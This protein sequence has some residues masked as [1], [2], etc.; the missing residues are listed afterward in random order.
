MLCN[1]HAY[2]FYLQIEECILDKLA[3][4]ENS[5]LY[6]ALHNVGDVVPSCESVCF[7]PSVQGDTS[8]G[9]HVPVATLSSP[10]LQR[11]IFKIAGDKV[12]GYR[13]FTG[14]KSKAI[15]TQS[16]CQ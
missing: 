5:P 14:I 16:P 6:D 7:T 1:V 10:V 8:S 4:E 13:K 11:P 12:V 3:W 9:T 15:K 2:C